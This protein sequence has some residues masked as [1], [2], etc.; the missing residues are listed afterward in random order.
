VKPVRVSFLLRMPMIVPPAPKTLDAVL[1]WAA[2][3]QAEFAGALDPLEH[4]HE[5]GIARHV[6]DDE[7]CPMASYVEVVGMSEPEPFHYI[8][9]QKL[10]SYTEAWLNGVLKTRPAFDSQ[11]GN[12]KAGLYVQSSCWVERITAWAVLDDEDRF[13]QLLPW[14]T[15]IGK[16]HHHDFGAVRSFEIEEEATAVAKWSKRPLPQGSDYG[17]ESHVMAMGGLRA[18]Y[19]KRSE[20]RPILVPLD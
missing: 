3:R 12:T 1:S 11:R 4:Q 7:W 17:A 6:V 9:R 5:T 8:K 19:W 14:V 16:L 20:Y 2:V 15:H 13:R 10:E 18:P